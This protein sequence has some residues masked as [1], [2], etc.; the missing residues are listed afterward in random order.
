[1]APIDCIG[2]RTCENRPEPDKRRHTLAAD[3]EWTIYETAVFCDEVFNYLTDFELDALRHQLVRVPFAGAYLPGLA[4]LMRIDFAAATVVYT[5]QPQRR[6]IAFIQIDRSVG[7]PDDIEEA[8]KSRLTQA[9]ALLRHAGYIATGK[10][11]ALWIVETAKDSA[12]G[13]D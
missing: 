1:M 6:V 3:E 11:L 2:E 4:P 10:Q 13:T 12:P 8:E 5:V 9:L 7:R